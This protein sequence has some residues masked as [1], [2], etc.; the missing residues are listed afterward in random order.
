[1]ASGTG[2]RPHELDVRPLVVRIALQHSQQI[3][4]RIVEIGIRGC[5]Q[6]E[7][8][9]G[10]DVGHASLLAQHGRPLLV[11]VLLEEVARVRGLSGEQSLAGLVVASLSQETDPSVGVGEELFDVSRKRLGP[12]CDSALAA[13]HV[14]VGIEPF[15]GVEH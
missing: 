15:L 10:G 7:R 1:M 6:R 14:V 12:Q 3:A 9:R 2:E 11:R 5:Q 8:V 4:R 13:R